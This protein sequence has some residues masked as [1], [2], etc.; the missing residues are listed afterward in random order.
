MRTHVHT[1]RTRRR[2]RA[3]AAVVGASLAVG[4]ALP[5]T[6]AVAADRAP[7]QRAAT[8]AEE[9]S[10]TPVLHP[11]PG[12]YLDGTVTVTA[13]PVLAGDPVRE[14]AVDG[15][16]LAGATATPATSR[17][18]FDVGSNSIEKRYG[19]HVLVNGTRLELDRDMVSERV[20]LDVPNDLL[21]QGENA[22]RSKSS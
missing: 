21:V 2:R 12:T 5:V 22:V 18:L 17:L 19:S 3:L 10:G 11:T 13:Q 8:A 9:P 16:P 14:L 7:T 15:Q 4:T 1:P 20:A 6:A